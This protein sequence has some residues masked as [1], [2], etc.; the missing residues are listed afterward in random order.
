[1]T[2]HALRNPKSPILDHSSLDPK[3]TTCANCHGD[4]RNAKDPADWNY[5]TTRQAAVNA[6]LIQLGG[7]VNGA[8]DA[9]AGGGLLGAFP[10]KRSLKYKHARWNYSMVLNDGSFGV[11]NFDYALELLTTSIADLMKPGT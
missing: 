5:V 1:M 2:C 10:D 7:A 4:A 9:N 8:P 11:H 6:L 3:I